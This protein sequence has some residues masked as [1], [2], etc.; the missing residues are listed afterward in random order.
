[1]KKGMSIVIAILFGLNIVLVVFIILLLTGVVDVNINNIKNNEDNNSIN[2]NID[3]GNVGDNID[4]ISD[5]DKYASIIDE[6]RN[7]MNDN[8][9]DDNNDNY[10]N[11]NQ[12]MISIY[13]K[14]KSGLYEGTMTINYC[15]YDINKDGNN[16][17]IVSG[18]KNNIIA[19][20]TYDGGTVNV[21]INDSCLGERCNVS[22]YDNGIIYFYGAGGAAV[23]GLTFYKIGNDGYSREI[24]KDF[25]VEIKDGIYN[26]E[27]DGVKTDFKS[28]KEAIDSV[29]N[30]A[31]VVDLSKLEF[32]EIK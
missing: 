3:N 22:I 13:H 18:T 26:I 14:H 17:L 32:K 29:V 15:Y 19:I 7:A 8:N 28:D 4:I 23:H 27:S 12:N 5:D 9:Y 30:G 31:S 21:F 1:M 16:E 20:Y 6:Y 10:K 25:G 2:N 11:I 24:V